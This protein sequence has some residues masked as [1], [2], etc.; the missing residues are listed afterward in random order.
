[1]S[2]N[3][4]VS[5]SRDTK[6]TEDLAM[7]VSTFGAAGAASTVPFPAP[8]DA[9]TVTWSGGT[10]WK[11]GK[12]GKSAHAALRAMAK[13]GISSA[14][15]DPSTGEP[16]AYS[17]DGS[18]RQFQLMAI[19]EGDVAYSPI[20]ETAYAADT[21]NAVLEGNFN[22]LFA[23]AASGSALVP[24]ASPSL[25][26]SAPS[27]AAGSSVDA[28]SASAHSGFVLHARPVASPVAFA[29]KAIAASMPRSGT[30][31][32]AFVQ[33]LA[34][35]YSGAGVPAE[36]KS[37]P[38][39][40]AVVSASASSSSYASASVADSLLGNSPVQ[41]A[42]ENADL[43]GGTGGEEKPPAPAADPCTTKTPGAACTGG[44]KYAFESK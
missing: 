26:L 23:K 4:Y 17:V 3:G 8:D 24:V 7:L 5:S 15:L 38:A 33:A 43:A 29:L 40:V 22:G 1:M 34:A 11:Q 18:G 37:L 32:A 42:K 19:A 6:R 39:V 36:A 28:G 31:K 10:L 2:F 30:A 16:Y 20:V 27:V 12:F 35:A 41:A 25:F 9:F 13:G 44:A 21:G 14:P